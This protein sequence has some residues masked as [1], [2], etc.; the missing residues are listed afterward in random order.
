LLLCEEIYSRLKKNPNE[1]F[2]I[3]I[4]KAFL[5]IFMNQCWVFISMSPQRCS[6][7]FQLIAA[8]LLKDAGGDLGRLRQK[9]ASSVP[10]SWTN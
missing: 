6:I 3:V 5:M 8:I 2:F 4:K 1:I 9:R 10:F 7:I